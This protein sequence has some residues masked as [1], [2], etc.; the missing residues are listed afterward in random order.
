MT[1]NDKPVTF[2]SSRDITID[3]GIIDVKGHA[4]W[5]RVDAAGDTVSHTTTVETVIDTKAKCRD[6][7][8]SAVTMVAGREIDST[9]KDYKI[10]READGS[11]GCPSGEI[12]HVNKASGRT[13]SVSF[14]GSNEATVTGPKGGTVQVPLVC[15]P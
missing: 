13:I 5:T 14:D 8:G 1:I 9:M 10:C 11:D 7:N 15:G 12:T 2:S 6:S 3:S 4:A